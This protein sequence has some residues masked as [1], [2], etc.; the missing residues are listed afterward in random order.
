MVLLGRDVI[1]S[2]LA[3][4]AGDG[5]SYVVAED[6]AMALAPL[7]VVL[8]RELGIATLMLEGG[9]HVNGSFLAAGLVDEFHVVLAP[10]LDGSHSPAI[11]EA[12]REGLKG[13]VTL[14]LS[15]CEHLD[16][17]AI[18]LRYAVFQA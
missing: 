8:R 6:E 12:G 18:H 10:A 7:L 16:N 13:K 14:S 4:L 9:G 17:G 15:S 2:H 3:E 5:V 11:V 1:D